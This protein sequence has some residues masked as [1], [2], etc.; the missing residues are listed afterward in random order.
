M[1]KIK[2]LVVMAALAL[3]S[4]PCF[5]DG[6]GYINYEKVLSN[7]DLAKNVARELDAKG[8]ELQQYLMDKEKEF[9]SI[10]TPVRQQAF[11]DKVANEYKAKEEAYIKYRINKEKEVF[12]KVQSAAKVIMAEQKLDAIIDIK[13]VFAGG[14]DITD[15]V[16]DRLKGIKN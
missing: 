4:A 16:I 14:V 3:V 13:A 11:K 8:M 7:Y 6:L 1:K 12:S 2:L 15:I 10:D 9:K 5:A